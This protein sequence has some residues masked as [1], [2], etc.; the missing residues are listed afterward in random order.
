MNKLAETA[1]HVGEFAREF[2]AQNWVDM[3]EEEAVGWRKALA[4]LEAA[5]ATFRSTVN[6]ID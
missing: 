6:L 4:D 3:D 1:E 2:A 5:A